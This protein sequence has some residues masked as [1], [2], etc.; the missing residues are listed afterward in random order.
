MWGGAQHQL[1]GC[2][3]ALAKYSIPLLMTWIIWT[4]P[5]CRS[6]W[7]TNYLCIHTCCIDPLCPSFRVL[8]GWPPPPSFTK[9][10]KVKF[11]LLSLSLASNQTWQLV[12]LRNNTRPEWKRVVW[13]LCPSGTQ[14][15]KS[16]LMTCTGNM[17]CVVVVVVV[18]AAEMD[19]SVGSCV[20]YVVSLLT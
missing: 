3:D 10:K 16:Q 1:W 13:N 11:L 4:T 20:D 14:R 2:P 7:S 12:I 8:L 18:V 6:I 17:D 15:T 9:K 19:R 5:E